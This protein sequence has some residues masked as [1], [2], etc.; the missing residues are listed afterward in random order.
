MD[1]HTFLQIHFVKSCNFDFS[2]FKT[3]LVEFF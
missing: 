2:S 3:E 1:M